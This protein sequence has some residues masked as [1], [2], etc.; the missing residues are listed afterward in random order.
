ARIREDYLRILRFFRF[1]AHYGRPGR[2][3]GAALAACA[4]GRAGL[5]R[6]SPERIGAELRKLLAA[7]DPAEALEL[8]RETGVLAQILPG[9]DAAALPALIAAEGAAGAPPDW[10]RR[11]AALQGGIPPAALT[12]AL[13]LS[14]AEAAHLRHLAEAAALDPAAAAFHHGPQMA[15]DGVLLA[16]AL[17]RPAPADWAARIEAARP[18]PATAAD[19][20]PLSGAALGAG[21]RRAQAAWIASGFAAPRQALIAAALET[22]AGKA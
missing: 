8:M 6:I 5:A 15:R 7:P 16:A 11:L 3:D 13:R 10:R 22:A 19:L 21:L 20:A 1:H 14:R 17:G 18:L 12:D 2:A 9:A 4:A